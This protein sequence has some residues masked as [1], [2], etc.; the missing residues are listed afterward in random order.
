MPGELSEQIWSTQLSAFIWESIRTP[1][2]CRAA[3]GC[4]FRPLS[5]SWAA[6]TAT[7]RYV[8]AEGTCSVISTRLATGAHRNSSHATG[9]VVV[10][11]L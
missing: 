3:A 4:A 6:I 2:V 10:S 5:P 11:L 8:Q 9:G 7:V 1:D